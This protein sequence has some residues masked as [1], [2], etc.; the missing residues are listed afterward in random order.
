MTSFQSTNIERKEKKITFMYEAWT[1]WISEKHQ[2]CSSSKFLPLSRTKEKR[3]WCPEDVTIKYLPDPES[4]RNDFFPYIL[5]FC[6]FLK[7]FF[8]FY[9]STYSMLITIIIFYLPVSKFT[10]RE[11]NEESK[12]FIKGMNFLNISRVLEIF[13]LGFER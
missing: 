2:N 6:L 10:L 4:W 11:L 5:K 8:F 1:I 3:R 13:S 9:I 12:L 7:F